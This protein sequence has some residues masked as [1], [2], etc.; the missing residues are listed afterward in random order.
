MYH[1]IVRRKVRR[2]FEDLNAGRFAGIVAQFAP[3]H[4]HAMFGRHPLAGVR[5]TMASTR[6][7]Y[8][9]LQ[10]LLPRLRFT[11][12]S[13]AVSGWPW[14]TRILVSW[15]DEFALPDGVLG[16]N[17][18]VHDMRMAWGKVRSLEVHC[19]TERLQGYCER[20]RALGVAEAGAAPIDDET[21]GGPA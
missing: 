15:S 19:D 20:M 6:E 14:D 9:R 3:R 4:R 8:A 21:K 12:K 2:A 1:F 16:T 18:G 7:W 13:V 17:Q 5:T 10:R 11:V